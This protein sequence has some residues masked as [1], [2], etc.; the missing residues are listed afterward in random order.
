MIKYYNANQRKEYSLVRDSKL[1]INYHIIKN[2]AKEYDEIGYMDSDVGKEIESLFEEG[3]AV[4]IHRVG[5]TIINDSVLSNIF[6]HGLYNNGDVMSSGAVGSNLNINKTVSFCKNIL[7]MIGSIKSCEGYKKSQGCIIIKIPKSFIGMGDGV[8]QPIY[9]KDNNSQIRL[10]PEF[11]YGYIP[12]I[13]K[14]VYNIIHNPNY[15]DDHKLI[16]D[17]FYYDRGAYYKAKYDGK[18]LFELK[19][20][21]DMQRYN[22]LYKAYLDTYIKYGYNQAITAL[23]ELI[24]KHNVSFF[25][26]NDNRINLSRFVAYNDVIKIM[27]LGLNSEKIDINNLINEFNMT[28]QEN[29]NNDKENTK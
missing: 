28:I 14:Q 7:T 5:Y 8:V 9:Y 16:N 15:K 12:V 1:N 6:N 21:S 4:G 22:I 13:D 17:N 19:H 27:M 20:L 26:G 2:L 25:S 23:L 29:V 18:E 10:L 11:I 24:N 3:Y